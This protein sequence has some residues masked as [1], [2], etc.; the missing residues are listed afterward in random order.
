MDLSCFVVF[1]F[2]V[3]VCVRNFSK[4][5][6]WYPVSMFGQKPSFWPKATKTARK[7]FRPE[8][9]S[10]CLG[11]LGPKF[12]WHFLAGAHSPKN[13]LSGPKMGAWPPKVK[14]FPLF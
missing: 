1:N 10:S 9:K 14:K 2:E 7:S 3:A 13:E 4:K 12:C 6:G 5:F 8:P 11:L